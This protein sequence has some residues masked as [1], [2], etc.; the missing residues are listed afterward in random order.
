[1]LSSPRLALAPFAVRATA[2]NLITSEAACGLRGPSLPGPGHIVLC[3]LSR[4]SADGA[5]CPAPAWRVPCMRIPQTAGGALPFWRRRA[6]PW[7]RPSGSIAINAA[8]QNCRRPGPPG[9]DPAQGVVFP[10]AV[11]A[12]R[13]TAGPAGP[14]NANASRSQREKR[15]R[16]SRPAPVSCLSAWRVAG[17][18]PQFPGFARSKM[19]VIGRGVL[20]PRACGRSLASASR[21]QTFS[22]Q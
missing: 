10:G 5:M 18:R 19:D 8:A 13:S 17:R 12:A 21:L 1:M 14:G 4:E 20:R 22:T 6:S 7:R 9:G 3:A 16:A 11:S 15:V 2:C